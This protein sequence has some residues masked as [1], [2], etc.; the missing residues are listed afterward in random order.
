MKYKD[1]KALNYL[2][3]WERLYHLRDQGQ[4]TG[5][6]GAPTFRDQVEEEEE[7]ECKTDKDQPVS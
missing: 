6:V 3:P 7:P 2:K 4:V 1:S 5:P